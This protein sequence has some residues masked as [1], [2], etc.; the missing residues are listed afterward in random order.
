MRGSHF[1]AGLAVILVLGGCVD[2]THERIH[3]P[4]RVN[5]HAPP[6]LGLAKDSHRPSVVLTLHAAGR[7]GEHDRYWFT[8]PSSGDNGQAGNVVT[9]WYFQR[10]EARAPLVIVVPIYGSS[11]YPSWTM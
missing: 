9:G 6:A 7:Q 10:G 4:A 8:M 11:A 1:T 2:A 5:G 3:Q